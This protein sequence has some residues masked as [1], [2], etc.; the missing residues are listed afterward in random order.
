MLARIEPLTA[1]DGLRAFD[2]IDVK[3]FCKPR[4]GGT[5]EAMNSNSSCAQRAAGAA[6]TSQKRV[7][8]RPAHIWGVSRAPTPSDGK[9]RCSADSL[10]V[11]ENI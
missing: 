6:G 5:T 3:P 9:V 4:W 8:G 11:L 1:V 10:F 2:A 7:R